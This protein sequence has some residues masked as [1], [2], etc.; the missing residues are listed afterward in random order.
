MVSGELKYSFPSFFAIF[1]DLYHENPPLKVCISSWDISTLLLN[2][3]LVSVYFEALSEETVYQ[4][5]SMLK[6]AVSVS[7]Q[8]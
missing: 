7:F 4:L 1:T 3:Y 6:N 8:K 2:E 5:L